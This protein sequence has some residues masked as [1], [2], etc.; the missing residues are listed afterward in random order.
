MMQ[1]ID[2]VIIEHSGAG[3]YAE[4]YG[5]ADRWSWAVAIDLTDRVRCQTCDGFTSSAAA[6]RSLFAFIGIEKANDMD[7]WLAVAASLG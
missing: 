1:K 6:E 4:V 3:W 2:Q 7:R 5:F